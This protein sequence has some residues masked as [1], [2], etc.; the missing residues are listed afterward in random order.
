MNDDATVIGGMIFLLG[1]LLNIVHGHLSP[2]LEVNLRFWGWLMILV[3]LG[4]IAFGLSSG[5]GRR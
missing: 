4:I 3:G 5:G 1:V 2:L